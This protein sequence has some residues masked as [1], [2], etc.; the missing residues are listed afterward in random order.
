MTV[1]I[2]SPPRILRLPEVEQATGLSRPTIYRL[3]RN[4]RF[5]ISIQIGPRAVGWHA[6]EIYAFNANHQRTLILSGT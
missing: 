2:E 1:R 4:N 5:P 3:M 6:E